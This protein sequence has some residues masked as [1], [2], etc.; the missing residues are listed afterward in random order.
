MTLLPTVARVWETWRAIPIPVDNFRADNGRAL[1]YGIECDLDHQA[2]YLSTMMDALAGENPHWDFKLRAG[3]E[4]R[5]L[6]NLTERIEC[7]ELPAGIEAPLLNYIGA[8]RDL[9]CAIIDTA[10]GSSASARG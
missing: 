5:E 2:S 3:T 10:P 9:L 1:T 6:N 7:L 8:T 4:L